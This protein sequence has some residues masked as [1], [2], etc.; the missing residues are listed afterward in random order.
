[1]I[2]NKS[3][4]ICSKKSQRKVLLKFEMHTLMKKLTS[5]IRRLKQYPKK[6]RC[7]YKKQ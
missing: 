3:F 1:M 2:M 6:Q 4:F 7:I 5:A